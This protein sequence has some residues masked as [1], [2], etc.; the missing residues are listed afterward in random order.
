MIKILDHRGE[1]PRG[2]RETKVLLTPKMNLTASRSMSMG[3]QFGLTGESHTSEN[4][5]F[6]YDATL[7]FAMTAEPRE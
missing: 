2:A 7:E 6:A 4:K 5:E 1:L 3:P